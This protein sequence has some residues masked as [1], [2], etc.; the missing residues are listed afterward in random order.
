MVIG[1]NWSS[2]I[3]AIIGCDKKTI[4][5]NDTTLGLDVAN[6]VI[7]FGSSSQA[8]KRAQICYEIRDFDNYNNKTATKRRKKKRAVLQDL[9]PLLLH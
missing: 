6:I 7:A 3:F 4:T 2:V 8:Y 1:L 5:T 9:L